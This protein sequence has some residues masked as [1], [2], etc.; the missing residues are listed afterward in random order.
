MQTVTRN[1]R[2]CGKIREN[3]NA[4]YKYM[5]H[6]FVAPRSKTI[7]SICC[8]NI[9]IVW[10]PEKNPQKILRINTCFVCFVGA[11][12]AK[13]TVFA[14]HILNICTIENDWHGIWLIC[15]SN[16][17]SSDTTSTQ[18]EYF[19]EFHSLIFTK[20]TNFFNFTLY[21]LPK[22]RLDCLSLMHV[23]MIAILCCVGLIERFK[24]IENAIFT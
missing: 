15:S 22:A 1:L 5:L 12:N 18:K 10:N 2:S 4:S 6:M 9:S 7:D 24:P 13:M 17:Q 3:N 8:F 20:N 19:I 14:V 21:I 11:V 16:R 23:L